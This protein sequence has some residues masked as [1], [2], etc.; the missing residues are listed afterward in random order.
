MWMLAVGILLILVLSLAPYS[1]GWVSTWKETVSQAFVLGEGRQA[2]APQ[3]RAANVP[4]FDAA[5]WYTS[6]GEAPETHGVLIESLNGERVFASH[7][8]DEVFNPASLVKLTTT[9]VALKKLGADYR[10]QTRV[11][12]DGTVD[13]GGDFQGRLLIMG[14]DPTFGDVAANLIANDLRARGIKRLA[15]ELF[16]SQDFSFNFSESPEKSAEYLSKAMRLGNPKTGVAEEPAGETLLTLNS[17][18][19]HDV[20]LYMNARSSN[21]I[22][23]RVGAM[24]GGPQSVQQFLINELKLPADKVLIART[25]GREH[26]RMTPRGLL[27]VI[28]ALIDAAKRQGLEPTDILPVASDDAGTLR[29]RFTGTG[30]E[31]AVV[32]KT[33]TLTPEVDGGMAS[34][35]GIVYANDG[36]PV[37]F[38]ILDQ[39]NRIG[40]NRQ[41]ED[42]LLAEV[43]NMEA[44]PRA[45]GS[46]TP[47]PLLPSASLQI[48]AEA[49]ALK[50]QDAEKSRERQK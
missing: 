11:L 49:T 48:Q 29:R 23:E 32:G 3:Q 1:L 22:A 18:P 7:N 34:I 8:A 35:A 16:V 5:V 24:V 21:F 50:Y 4:L 17:Y 31:G 2:D 19:L 33:G 30:L 41:M 36:S 47:R 37:V 42:Q 25:S 6:R 10:F 15:G 13:R 27:A 14:N 28:R 39:G 45:V 44:K 9:L 46:P 20:L 40:D 38:A 12:V 26:N 43:F